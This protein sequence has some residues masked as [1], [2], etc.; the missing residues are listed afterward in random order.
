[1]NVV[2][3]HELSLLDVDDAARAARR[4]QQI[5]LPAE[6]S[7]NLQDVGHRGHRFGL[8][9]L[10][11]IG[12]DRKAFRLQPGQNA[13]SFDEA[14]PAIGVQAGAVG[15]VKRRLED[16]AA[17]HGVANAARHP[18]DVLF[19]F[20]HARSG[21]QHQRTGCPLG[22]A[23]RAELNRHSNTTSPLGPGSRRPAPAAAA[24]IRKRP[25]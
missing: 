11:N 15:L 7:G 2:R 19:A 24:G 5:G 18:V 20:D 9:R 22:P 21:D 14:R 10:M 13:Q 12:E 25:R 23:E 17:A 8:R 4:Q 1:M 3:R 16:E 6:E